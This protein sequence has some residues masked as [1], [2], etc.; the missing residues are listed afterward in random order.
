MALLPAPHWRNPR[1]AARAAP[2]ALDTWLIAQ[3]NLRN[4]RGARVDGSLPELDPTLT[5][6][7]IVLGLCAAQAPADGRISKLVLRILQSGQLDGPHL[8]WLARRE[9]ADRALHWL[10]GLVPPVER[11]APVEELARLFATP[12]RGYRP[13]DFLYDPERLI[14]RPFHKSPTLQPAAGSRSCSPRW[15]PSVPDPPGLLRFF[16]LAQPHAEL[17]TSCSSLAVRQMIDTLAPSGP[18]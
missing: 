11:T 13:P 10:L 6:Q 4:L 17:T 15:G 9:R 8:H 2:W 3:A 12:P 14:R 1:L 7:E 18:P 16:A 5:L